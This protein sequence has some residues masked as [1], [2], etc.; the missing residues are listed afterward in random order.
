MPRTKEFI[1]FTNHIW[2]DNKVRNTVVIVWYD[3]LSKNVDINYIYGSACLGY[4]LYLPCQAE[5]TGSQILHHI[6]LFLLKALLLPEEYC[7]IF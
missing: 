6:K 5:S 1:S 7:F 2:V 3:K 4:A